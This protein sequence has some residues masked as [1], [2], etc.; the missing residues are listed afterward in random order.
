LP[1]AMEEFWKWVTANKRKGQRRSPVTQKHLCWS[2]GSAKKRRDC[3]HELRW[4]HVIGSRFVFEG[5]EWSALGSRDIDGCA[6]MGNLRSERAGASQWFPEL[7]IYDYRHRH[8]NPSLGRFLQ[9]DPIGL[10]TE[11]A[12][13]M[14]EQKALYGAGAP[15]AFT[16]SEMNLFRYCGDDPVDGSDPLGLDFIL[17]N[18]EAG[19]YGVG[20]SAALVENDQDG[21]MYYSKNGAIGSSR[22]G[23]FGTFKAFQEDKLST[24]YERGLRITTAPRDD[25]AM[26]AYGDKNYDKKYDDVKENCAD[27]TADIAN[28]GGL[29]LGKPKVTGFPALF[30][31]GATAPNKQYDQA[32]QKYKD[33]AAVTPHIKKDK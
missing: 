20:H 22:A 6:G 11:G 31:N 10:Q 18:N 1:R 16:S 5:S 19:A 24:R 23:P 21:W 28:K 33:A 3:F 4:D 30:A 25:Q 2:V 32:K 15:E 9:T 14:P 26:K 7:R 8:Y 29:D 27:L 12:K 17:L 13:L